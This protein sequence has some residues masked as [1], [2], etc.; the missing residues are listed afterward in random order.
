MSNRYNILSF[1]L[2]GWQQYQR[3]LDL[4]TRM[5]WVQGLTVRCLALCF[6]L[7]FMLMLICSNYVTLCSSN[8][9]M[10]FLRCFQANNSCDLNDVC[11][12]YGNM[13]ARKKVQNSPLKV[14][15]LWR[16]LF[17]KILLLLSC[18]QWVSYLHYGVMDNYAGLTM[19][20]LVLVLV[21]IL[22]SKALFFSQEHPKTNVCIRG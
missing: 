10:A 15:L 9:T 12:L 11:T 2:C 19:G 4:K 13:Y 18:Q 22:I 16:Q 17:L 21:L 20:K 1:H 3:A 5:K 7:L 8:F 14:L 6:I